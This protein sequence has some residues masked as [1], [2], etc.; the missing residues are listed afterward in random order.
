MDASHRKRIWV[1]VEYQ[2]KGARTCGRGCYGVN[3]QNPHLA[4]WLFLKRDAIDPVEGWREEYSWAIA[5]SIERKPTKES[6][7]NSVGGE[8]RNSF[9]ATCS[10]EF[11]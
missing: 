10:I 7:L 8:R 9:Y 4:M 1:K 6:V 2:R 5:Y 3:G 11:T